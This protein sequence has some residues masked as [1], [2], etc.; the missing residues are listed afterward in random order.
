MSTLIQ[1]E[2]VPGLQRIAD[3]LMSQYANA[4]QPPPKVLYTDRDC[5]SEHGSS[6]YL[7][8]I[9]KILTRH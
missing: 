8:S 7:V 4:G 3:G 1:S 2:G 6:M 5:C 9:F